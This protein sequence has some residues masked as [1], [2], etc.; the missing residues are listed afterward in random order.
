MPDPLHLC[1][2]LGPLAVYLLTIGM[3]NLRSRPVVISGL[4][5]SLLL[6]L[7][8]S[9]LV[10]AGPCE[11]F[12][13]ETTAFKLG[14][15]AWLLLLLL[16]LLLLLLVVLSQRPRIVIYNASLEQ[17]RPVLSEISQELDPEVRWAGDAVA[18]PRSGINLHLESFVAFRN[19]QLQSTGDHQNFEGWHRLE[20]M[21]R[22]ATRAVPTGGNSCAPL[23]IGAAV[24]LGFIVGWA[25]KDFETLARNLNDLLRK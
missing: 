19:V 2:A 17:I 8:V 11:L 15:W 9:G 3:W 20:L 12:L 23:L 5:D 18:L 25:G 14:G 16:Y 21:L 7:G 22:A 10:L 24:V 4:L 13:S 6:G 1:I